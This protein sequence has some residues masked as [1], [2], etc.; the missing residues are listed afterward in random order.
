MIFQLLFNI[1]KWI[2]QGLNTICH[3]ITAVLVVF[4][5]LIFQGPGSASEEINDV[6]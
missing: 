5:G 2:F 1:P 4:W 6:L 3:Y